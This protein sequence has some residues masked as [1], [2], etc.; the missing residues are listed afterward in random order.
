MRRVARRK[1]FGRDTGGNAA[2]KPKHFSYIYIS[3]YTACTYDPPSP[4]FLMLHD[5]ARAA[6][7]AATQSLGLYELSS[8]MQLLHSPVPRFRHILQHQ[9]QHL[10]ILV[11]SHLF[12][13]VNLH[14]HSPHM[15]RSYMRLDAHHPPLPS[16]HVLWDDARRRCQAAMPGGEGGITL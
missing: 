9:M 10:T 13:I 5:A 8:E 7:N 16:S 6:S 3:P 1:E 15:A 14:S 12:S 2:S 4:S 11:S